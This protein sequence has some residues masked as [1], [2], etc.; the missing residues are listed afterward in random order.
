MVL[1]ENLFNGLGLTF[2]T[3]N[4]MFRLRL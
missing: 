3:G 1:G 4:N 2:I